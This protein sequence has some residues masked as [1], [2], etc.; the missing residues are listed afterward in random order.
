MFDA[1]RVIVVRAIHHKPM[2]L[3]D[4]NHLH[5]KCLATGMT[6][7]QST[8]L[9]LAFSIALF[10][11]NAWLVDVCNINILFAIDLLLGICFSQLLNIWVLYHRE[12]KTRTEK[13]LD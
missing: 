12:Q 1:C 6:H 13:K 11:L 8:E 4:R 9:V 2:F 10:I 5:H 3:A 7:L